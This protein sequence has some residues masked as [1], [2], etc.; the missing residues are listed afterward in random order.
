[1]KRPRL[2]SAAEYDVVRDRHI[3]CYLQRAGTTAGIKRQIRRRERRLG[4]D[5]V[6]EQLS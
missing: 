2:R 1:M 6:E 5:S 3:Y 4:K